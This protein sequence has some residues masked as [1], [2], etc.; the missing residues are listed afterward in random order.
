MA[1]NDAEYLNPSNSLPVAVG[2]KGSVERVAR[3]ELLKGGVTLRHS[4]P[5]ELM[6]IVISGVWKFYLDD[7]TVTVSQDQVLRLP[8]YVEHRTEA[9]TD[10]IALTISPS[11]DAHCCS[12][13]LGSYQDAAMLDDSL[14]DPDPYLWGV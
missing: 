14:Q 7:R 5:V 12:A 8:A 3:L 9:L 10:A 1:C 4:H 6:V 11:S 2:H 13:F